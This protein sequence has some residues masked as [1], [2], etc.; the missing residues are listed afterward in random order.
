MWRHPDRFRAESNNGPMSSFFGWGASYHPL[1][2]Y[3]IARVRPRSA[4]TIPYVS[5]LT[6]RLQGLDTKF[7]D[8][9]IERLINLFSIL[10]SLVV[11]I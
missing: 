1:Y 2:M 4:P 7:L 3:I 10:H 8:V 11:S 9:A 5:C 6:D